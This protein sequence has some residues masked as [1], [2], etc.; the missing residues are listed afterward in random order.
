MQSQEPFDYNDR[1]GVKKG[2][3][4][5]AIALVTAIVGIGWITWAGLHH[6]NPTF[7]VQVITFVVGDMREVS[8]RYSVDRHSTITATICTV[9]ARDYEKNIVGQIDQEIPAGEAKVELV[10]VVPTRSEAVNAD[11]ISCR[12]K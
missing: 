11:V 5:I 8:V 3:S 12:A 7:R 9:I 6:S 10:T 1:Y 2:R 4:W